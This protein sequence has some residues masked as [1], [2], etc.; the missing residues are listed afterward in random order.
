MCYGSDNRVGNA[1]MEVM[2]WLSRYLSHLG[3]FPTSLTDLH[4]HWIRSLSLYGAISVVKSH[5]NTSTAPFAATA[6]FNITATAPPYSSSLLF[7]I[8]IAIVVVGSDAVISVF[9]VVTVVAYHTTNIVG[10][11]SCPLLSA[12]PP[13]SL[14]LGH[15]RWIIG[16]GSLLMFVHDPNRALISQR[17]D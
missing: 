9:I 11:N 5:C 7:Q 16:T 1:S 14:A 17:W 6:T 4:L 12:C 8:I 15:W 3:V 10:V 13:S 2:D